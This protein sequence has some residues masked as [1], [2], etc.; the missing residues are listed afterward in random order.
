M[1]S[2]SID[3]LLATPDAEVAARWKALQRRLVD[4]FGREPNVEAVLF[5]LGIQARGRGYEPKLDRQI[6]QDLI[7]EGT[8]A[9]FEALGLYERVGMEADGAWIWERT[10]PLPEMDVGRQEKLLKLA[11]LAYFD[12]EASLGPAP[13]DDVA[14]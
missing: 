11:I 9:A 3:D 14:P 8:Y 1:P 4:R 5:L 6:K 7:M 13:T 10:H 12:A 2:R